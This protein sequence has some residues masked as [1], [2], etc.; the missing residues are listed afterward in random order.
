MCDA[1]ETP[2]VTYMPRLVAMAIKVA[3]KKKKSISAKAVS[4]FRIVPVIQGVYH[5]RHKKMWLDRLK[6]VPLPRKA[7]VFQERVLV[8]CIR[9]FEKE[10]LAWEYNELTACEQYPNGSDP[11]KYN[12]AKMNKHLLSTVSLD[13]TQTKD[14]NIWY[15]T[16]TSYQLT[17]E[18]GRLIALSGLV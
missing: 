15:T 1:Y 3:T 2:S 7:W 5:L 18:T 12:F 6:K 11:K 10:Q 14:L 16:Y 4:G 13:T 8:P 9:H 17:K